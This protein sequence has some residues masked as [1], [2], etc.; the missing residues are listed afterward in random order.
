MSY[1]NPDERHFITGDIV[2]IVASAIL[3]LGAIGI[4]IWLIVDAAEQHLV[5]NVLFGSAFLLITFGLVYFSIALYN[6]PRTARGY[7]SSL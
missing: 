1:N 5:R 2:F 4:F 6:H 7:F 3:F